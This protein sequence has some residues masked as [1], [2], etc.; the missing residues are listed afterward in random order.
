MQR[1]LPL[2]GEAAR[3]YRR[4]VGEH[5]QVDETYCRVRGRWVYAYRAIDQEGQ[6]VDVFVSARRNAKAAQAFFTRAIATTGVTPRRIITDKARCHPH[7]FAGSAYR[8]S[9]AARGI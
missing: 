9:I 5:W 7:R 6:V 8:W 1:F 4:P 2:F 3:A